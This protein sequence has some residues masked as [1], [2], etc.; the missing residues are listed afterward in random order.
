[1]KWDDI[2]EKISTLLVIGVII[3]AVYDFFL[4]KDDPLPTQ[5]KYKYDIKEYRKQQSEI[6][7]YKEECLQIVKNYLRKY[8]YNVTYIYTTDASL[9]DWKY[10]VK[11]T[12]TNP[13]G[14]TRHFGVMYDYTTKSITT[15]DIE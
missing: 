4:K 7:E 5:N 2:L 3:W 6:K 10:N 1:M 15:F 9:N 8:G 12:I 13:N 14:T 11:G